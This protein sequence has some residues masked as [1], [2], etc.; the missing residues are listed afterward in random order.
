MMSNIM[1][2]F[3]IGPPL[4]ASGQPQ[5]IG[6]IKYTTGSVRSVGSSIRAQSY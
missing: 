5:V 3:D 1:A 2:M 6:D 4:D